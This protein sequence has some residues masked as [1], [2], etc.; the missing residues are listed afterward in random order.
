MLEAYLLA[1]SVPA[2]DAALIADSVSVIPLGIINPSQADS[3]EMI[4]FGHQV[5]ARVNFW[6]ADLGLTMDLGSHFRLSGGVSWASKDRVYSGSGLTD[7]V[8]NSPRTRGN[9]ALGYRNT[10]AGFAAEA[11][12]RSIASFPVASGPFRGEVEA[13]SVIDVSASYNLA[14][15]PA[16]TLTLSIDNVLNERHREFVGAPLLGRLVLARVRADF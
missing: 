11:R 14:W 2:P 16:I 13:Y 3:T 15:A 9:L 4:A 6:G 12:G 1:N 5:T 8:F 7:V 10:P